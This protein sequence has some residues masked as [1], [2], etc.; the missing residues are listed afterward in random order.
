MILVTHGIVG[1]SVALSVTGNPVLGGVLAFASH[2]VLDMIPHWDYQ[3][4]SLSQSND[5]KEMFIKKGINL[6][7]DICKVAFDG[8]LGLSVPL[9]ITLLVLDNHLYIALIGA[10]CGIIPDFLQAVYFK[11]HTKIL[12]KFAILSIKLHTKIRFDNR[13]VIGLLMQSTLWI[14]SIVYIALI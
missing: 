14:A 12:E 4:K 10:T 8:L 6:Y 13:P 3:V 5:A 7:T 2:F 1:A 11:T 9:V